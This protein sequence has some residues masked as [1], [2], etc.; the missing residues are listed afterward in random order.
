VLV[1]IP[2]AGVDAIIDDEDGSLVLLHS[3][4]LSKKGYVVTNVPHPEGGMVR[5]R[6]GQ[7]KKRTTTLRLSRLLMGLEWGDSRQVDHINHNI[8]DHQRSNLEIVTNA[9]NAQ[10]RLSRRGSSSQYRGVS[11]NVQFLRW[12]AYGVV[13]G[14]NHYLGLFVDEEE[15]AH[16]AAEWRAE[17]MPYSP[18]GRARRFVNG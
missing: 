7:F 11:W 12:M 15:A 5:S 18:E 6:P 8:L 10:N 1:H 16:V 4:H 13:N 2:S 17:N 14:K 9:G 3:W